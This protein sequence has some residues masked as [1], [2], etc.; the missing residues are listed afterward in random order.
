MVDHFAALGMQ[1][2]E[3]PRVREM[4]KVLDDMMQ[5]EVDPAYRQV[6]IQPTVRLS[7]SVKKAQEQVK[8]RQN[9]LLDY[10]QARAKVKKYFLK[11]RL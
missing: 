8:K 2:S 7:E 6:I 4:S 11:Q 3:M 10:D 5:L 1:P 9:K